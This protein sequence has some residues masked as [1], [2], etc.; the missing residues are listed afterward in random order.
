MIGDPH[1]V[2]S[3]PSAVDATKT[4]YENHSGYTTITI[5]DNGKILTAEFEPGEVYARYDTGDQVAGF[6]SRISPTYPV[7]L[8]CSSSA[9]PS[10]GTYTADC[11]QGE[12]WNFLTNGDQ[13]YSFRAGILAQLSYTPLPTDYL[14][15]S[16]AALALPQSLALSTLL[17]GTAH[18]CAGVYTI[19][20]PAQYSSYIPT[21]LGVCAAPAPHGLHTTKGSLYLQDQV[22][23]SLDL[24]SYPIFNDEA[25]SDPGWDLGNSGFFHVEVIRGDD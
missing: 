9:Y 13:I 7:A 24:N 17:T 3:Q 12:G 5:D 8:N 23:G 16:P 6:G 15:S 4:L 11:Q 2:T 19:L 14:A 22:G 10:D 25:A 20:P 21:D 18:T 1:A